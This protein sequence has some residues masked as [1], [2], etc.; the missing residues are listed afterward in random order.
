MNWERD[1]T[2]IVL[3]SGLVFFT[4]CVLGVCYTKPDDGQLYTLFSGAFGYFLGA[5][6]MHLK[7][8][9]SPPPDTQVETTSTSHTKTEIV[10]KDKEG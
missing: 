2:L 1:K 9:E 10:D 7:T 8:K 6:G 4:V 3:L 5:L